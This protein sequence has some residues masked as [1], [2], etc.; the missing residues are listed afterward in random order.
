M[1]CSPAAFSYAELADALPSG[2]YVFIHHLLDTGDPAA[3]ELQA[4]MRKGLGRVRFRTL[5]EVSRLFGDLP[6]VEPGLVPIPEWRPDPGTPIRADYGV[7]LS[8]ACAGVARKP[9]CARS[10]SEAAGPAPAPDQRVAEAAAEL[11]RFDSIGRTTTPSR[12]GHLSS[13]RAGSPVLRRFQPVSG[14]SVYAPSARNSGWN[15]RTPRD[16]RNQRTKARDRRRSRRTLSRKAFGLVLLAGVAGFSDHLLAGIRPADPDCGELR[17]RARGGDSHPRCDVQAGSRDAAGR[18]VLGGE[19]AAL[20]YASGQGTRFG[21]WLLASN[22]WPCSWHLGHC[23]CC[24]FAGARRAADPVLPPTPT[25]VALIVL[26][27]HSRWS[28]RSLTAWPGSR[29]PRRSVLWWCPSS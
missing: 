27:G 25:G 12:P 23:A 2:S 16:P 24:V 7:I 28:P 8:M 3:A 29:S 14:L 6:L 22:S 13:L 26:L 10:R 5:C 18:L 1:T 15:Q 19:I 20:L 21:Q 4:Q 9:L 11:A 17:P